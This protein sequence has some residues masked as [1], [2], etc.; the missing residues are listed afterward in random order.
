MLMLIPA[1]AAANYPDSRVTVIVRFFVDSI[2]T[3]IIVLHILFSRI[4]L[5]VNC[6]SPYNRS[7]LK[8]VLA[9]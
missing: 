5:A 7:N 3:L 9:P 4:H 2:G 1:L 8:N 6:I